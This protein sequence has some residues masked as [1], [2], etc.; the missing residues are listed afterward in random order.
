MSKM[1]KD[2][3]PKFFL[4]SAKSAVA[5]FALSV[6]LPA[7]AEEGFYRI[8][9]LPVGSRPHPGV[10]ERASLASFKVEIGKGLVSN[11]SG[12]FISRDGYFLT[13]LHC[14]DLNPEVWN[15]LGA[16]RQKD[17][18]ISWMTIRN[19]SPENVS[20]HFRAEVPGIGLV[21]RPARV[22]VLGKGFTA[23]FPEYITEKGWDLSPASIQLVREYSEDFMILKVDLDGKHAPCMPVSDRAPKARDRVW[24]I[25]YPEAAKRLN[26]KN[27][28]GESQY[29]TFGSVFSSYRSNFQLKSLGL[30]EAAFAELDQMLISPGRF[31]HNADAWVAMSGGMVINDSGEMVG[32]IAGS[33]VATMFRDFP[34]GDSVFNDV[35]TD[36]V[37]S[38]SVRKI[39][40]EKLGAQKVS[41]IFSC[42]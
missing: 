2:S 13:A 1:L 20:M 41:E 30:S 34:Q 7:V 5:I 35:A 38:T 16:N 28:D 39:V 8:N 9:E 11:C 37:T 19:Q 21:D 4:K 6:T 29:V 25:G 31:L 40:F 17:G 3:K 42:D 33:P 10:L 18:D 36:S 23:G 12:Q 15:A 22:V 27:S 32:T 26:G 24:A 14:M